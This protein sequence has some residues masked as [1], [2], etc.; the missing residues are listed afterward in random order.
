MLNCISLTFLMA[1]GFSNIREKQHKSI[2]WA[3]SCIILVQVG[4]NLANVTKTVWSFRIFTITIKWMLN[5]YPRENPKSPLS[6]GHNLQSS[7]QDH[8][9]TSLDHYPPHEFLLGSDHWTT[10]ESNHIAWSHM[11]NSSMSCMVTHNVPGKS[12]WVR[13]YDRQQSCSLWSYIISRHEYCRHFWYS[14][15]GLEL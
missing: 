9:N 11:M 14:N 8:R 2:S 7:K 5:S 1:E 10:L 13:Y 3:T 6:Q 15:S 12:L 4:L